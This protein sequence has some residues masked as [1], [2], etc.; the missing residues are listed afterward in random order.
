MQSR[1]WIGSLAGLLA[2]G[3]LPPPSAVAEGCEPS[4][5]TPI[6]QATR[7]RL[8]AAGLGRLPLA[9]D[10][11]RV[12]LVAPPFSNPTSVTNP[13]FPISDLRSAILNG[14][15]D[16]RPLKIETTLLP[17]TRVAEWAPGQCVRTLVSQF[18]A[19]VDGRIEEVAL[20]RYAQADDGSVWYF[21]ED[22]FN[23]RGGVVGDTEGTW[24]AGPDG[25]A[26]MI[27]P[28]HPRVGDVHRS[29]NV[30]G[31]VFEEVTI[32][33]VG[34]TVRG[35]RGAVRGA[36]VGSELHDDG[37]REDKVFAPGYGEFRSAGGGDLE[38]MALAVPADAQAG[39]PPR[40]LTRLRG[41]AIATFREARAGHRRAAA[42]AAARGRR[43]WR[44]RGPVPP[45]L[46]GPMDRALA[47]GATAQAA[48]ATAQA[49]L[50][51]EL[52]HRP[53]AAVDRARFRLWARRVIADA[54]AG[55]VRGVSGDVATLGWI[56]DRLAAAVD[57]VTL[58]RVDAVVND[59]VAAAADR[60]LRAARRGA[61]ALLAAI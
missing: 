57:E 7:A 43:A 20:D 54:E 60:D 58:A 45:R 32:K 23:Y 44:A 52:L 5:A 25:P 14:H 31:L 4:V 51:I 34:D 53:P 50:D 33:S 18:V 27:M 26:A 46:V 11:R 3:L 37:T 9:P 39:P 40:W 22:V 35:P 28:A 56:R 17:E 59:L 49:A 29:E 41:A 1:R 2:I 61:K 55:N 10:A 16:G 8:A 24:L 21:G 12:D 13:L 47:R 38:A 48:L 36:I 42:R 19:Y 30:P 15:V 6:P